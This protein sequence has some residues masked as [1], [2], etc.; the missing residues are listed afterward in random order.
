MRCGSKGTVSQEYRRKGRKD[1]S[2]RLW[3]RTYGLNHIMRPRSAELI[4]ARFAMCKMPIESS[5]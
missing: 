5:C 1:G 2:K 3:A 4:M